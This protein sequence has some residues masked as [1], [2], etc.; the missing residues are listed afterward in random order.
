MTFIPASSVPEDRSSTEDTTTTAGTEDPISEGSSTPIVSLFA[1]VSACANLH[2][3]PDSSTAGDREE[4][5]NDMPAFDYEVTDGLPPPMP[6]SGGWITAENMDQF[7]DE[8]GN[9]RGQGLGPGAGIVRER[10]DSEPV[11][12]GAATDEVVDVETK[13][14]RTG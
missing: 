7:F 10:E 11:V 5:D 4:D 8:N 6:G 3:S 1:A 12:D 9:W 14:R 2:A 13:W